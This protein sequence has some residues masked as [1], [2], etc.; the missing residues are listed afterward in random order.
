MQKVQSSLIQ[1]DDFDIQ[2]CYFTQEQIEN[3]MNNMSHEKKRF[4]FVIMSKLIMSQYTD[5]KS[6]DILKII[7]SKRFLFSNKITERYNLPKS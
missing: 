3:I 4:L 5:Y 2:I 1:S 6:G 7:S